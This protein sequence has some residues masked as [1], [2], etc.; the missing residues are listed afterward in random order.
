MSSCSYQLLWSWL[1]KNSVLFGLMHQEWSPAFLHNPVKEKMKSNGRIL[2]LFT[3]TDLYFSIP[4][5]SWGFLL[6]AFVKAWDKILA[7]PQYPMKPTDKS[8][9]RSNEKT[10]RLQVYPTSIT[11]EIWEI[12]GAAAEM[13]SISLIFQLLKTSP[14]LFTS[15]GR[16]SLLKS[17]V[18]PLEAG[19]LV[20]YNNSVVLSFSGT[21]CTVLRRALRKH[22]RA[23]FRMPVLL[24]QEGKQVS[25]VWES[26]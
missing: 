21:Y 14:L 11:S 10:R 18:T 22:D 15:S 9:R 8:N 4:I 3:A 6:N 1:W 17:S 2:Y 13:R 7:P 16:S 19:V 20:F 12:P 26:V 25:E 24:K 5:S 23:P